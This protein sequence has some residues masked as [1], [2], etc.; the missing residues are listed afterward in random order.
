[1]AVVNKSV[2]EILELE[3]KKKTVKTFADWLRITARAEA[4]KDSFMADL[5]Q[6]YRVANGA[7]VAFS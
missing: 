1:M 3:E 4:L 2:D 5:R 6:F 7:T